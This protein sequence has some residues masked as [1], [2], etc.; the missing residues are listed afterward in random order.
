MNIRVLLAIQYDPVILDIRDAENKY[1]AM[2]DYYVN[3]LDPL[4]ERARIVIGWVQTHR[5]FENENHN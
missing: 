1:W 5:Y 4:S 2:L 3:F